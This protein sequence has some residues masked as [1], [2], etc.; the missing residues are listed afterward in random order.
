MTV[1]LCERVAFCDNDAELDAVASCDPVC[2]IVAACELVCVSELVE[3]RVAV[4]VRPVDTL[5]DGEPDDDALADA[6]PLGEDGIPK[7][8]AS[9]SCRKLFEESAAR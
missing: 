8:L 9:Q 5:V 3:V 4:R 1:T 6:V 2:E 7:I